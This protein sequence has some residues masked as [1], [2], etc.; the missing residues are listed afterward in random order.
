MNKIDTVFGGKIRVRV[1]GICIKHDKILLVKHNMNGS[2]FYAPPGGGVEF[3]E[4]LHDTLTRE[5]KEETGLK[6]KSG[7]F[8]FISEFIRTPLHAIELFF[9]IDNTS[10]KLITGTDPETASDDIIEH[11]DYYSA[12]SIKQIPTEQLHH[13]L[14]NCNNPRDILELSGY[15]YPPSDLI[16]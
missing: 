2:P 10:G 12:A 13:I 1:C 14:R 5:F 8:L 7:P 3:G 4:K 6:I 16:K 11:V 9:E 15:V